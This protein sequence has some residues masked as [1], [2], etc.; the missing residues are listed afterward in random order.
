MARFVAAVVALATASCGA[1]SES[2]GK[3]NYAVT[4]RQNYEKGQ[5]SLKDEDWIAAA[6]YFAFVKA[7]FPY[8]KYAVLAEL[9]VAD[10]EFGAG[11]YLQAIDN[12]KLFMK[13]HP[14]HEA[15][16]NGYAAFR[17]GESYY[18]MLPGDFFI[19]P[20]SYEKDQS[21]TDDAHRELEQFVAKYPKSRYTEE[22]RKML[23]DIVHRLA[24]HELYVA[25]F[26]WDRDRP[27]G[28]VL[29][30]RNLLDR[31]AGTPLD[32]DALYLLGRAYLKVKMP[33]R[34]RSA[35]ERL[36]KEHPNHP[37]AKQARRELARLR[38]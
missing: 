26:Y 36:V 1:A 38:G 12:Y 10:A 20:P 21:A 33:D 24:E 8:S 37:D 7:R 3:V 11:H 28:T 19:L 23:M 27:M 13:F 17:V 34:A 16:T 2:T 29:R 9:R 35:F 31:H 30:L 4:A 22:A 32:G 6:K 14:T 18:K 25:R 15:T 5:K